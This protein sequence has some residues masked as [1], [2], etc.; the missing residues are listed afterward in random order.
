[1]TTTQAP[2]NKPEGTPIP[3]S[4]TVSAMR[5]LRGAAPSVMLPPAGVNLIALPMMLR[6]I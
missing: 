1:M 4:L 3:V 5:P 6:R 2:P